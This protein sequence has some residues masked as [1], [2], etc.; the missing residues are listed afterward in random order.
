VSLCAKI[1]GA[2]SDSLVTVAEADTI[3]SDV[4]PD[5]VDNWTALTT[6]QKEL[7]LRLGANLLGYMPLRGRKVFC[8]QAQSFPRTS[9]GNV[10]SIPDAAKQTQVFL[11]YSVVHRG[12]ANRPSVEESLSGMRVT[13]VS[14]GGMLNVSFAGGAVVSGSQLDQVMRS[15]QSPAYLLMKPWLSQ[16]RGGVVLNDEEITCS[17]TSTSSTTTTTTTTTA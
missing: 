17:T 11:A 13:N 3:V 6:A 10:H 16:L 14:L 12:L 7:R 15:A 9:Q 8:N 5:V 1:G 4:L 2:E